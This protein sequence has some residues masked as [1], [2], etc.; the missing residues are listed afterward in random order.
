MF[1]FRNISAYMEARHRLSRGGYWGRIQVNEDS[2]R[3]MVFT[4]E[5]DARLDSRK[6]FECTMSRA[7]EVGSTF[8]VA[9]PSIIQVI[10]HRHSCTPLEF[11]GRE[12][13][14]D[15]KKYHDDRDRPSWAMP[16]ETEQ[17]VSD[18]DYRTL[19]LRTYGAGSWITTEDQGFF[20]VATGRKV[21]NRREQIELLWDLGF[22]SR[23]GRPVH[24]AQEKWAGSRTELETLTELADRCW[25]RRHTSEA[26][27]KMVSAYTSINRYVAWP[28]AW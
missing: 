21:T 15:L 5:R 2:D 13:F 25:N 3:L 10:G 24:V 12:F 19:T 7:R 28:G 23:R 27:K 6:N 1:Q 17:Q 20:E 18:R 14:D 26:A 16:S 11:F 9:K 4:T 22:A 8:V